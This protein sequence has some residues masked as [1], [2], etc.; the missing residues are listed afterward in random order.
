MTGKTLDDALMTRQLTED[1][2]REK[3]DCF[4]DNERT[5]TPHF[6]QLEINGDVEISVENVKGERGGEKVGRSG[7]NPKWQ[8]DEKWQD[9]I[10]SIPTNSV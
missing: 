6:N 8:I 5:A 7:R 10:Q 3:E 4:S 9:A 2:L 1:R